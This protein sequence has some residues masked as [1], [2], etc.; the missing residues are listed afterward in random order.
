MPKTYFL[1][2]KVDQGIFSDEL[3]VTVTTPRGTFVSIVPK[4][5]IKKAQGRH[6]VAVRVVRSGH[7]SWA[8]IPS[9]QPESIPIK[10]GDLVPA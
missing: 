1:S 2:C 7:D 8:V 3:V 5:K 10:M 6:C 9:A 4:T